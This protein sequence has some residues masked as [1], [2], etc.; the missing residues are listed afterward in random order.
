V[1][2]A[3]ARA[4]AAHEYTTAAKLA[5]CL[6]DAGREGQAVHLL[7]TTIA[8]AEEADPAVSKADRL[9]MRWM[10]AW[11]VGEKTGGH[12]DP[13]R[14]LGIARDVVR[15]STTIYGPAHQATLDAKLILARQ[16]GAV[17]NPQEALI[18]AREVDAAATAGLCADDRTTLA[19]GSRSPSGPGMWT[20]PPQALNASPN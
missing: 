8:A 15:D 10:L 6:G 5:Y 16:V 13:Q 17:G 19:P 12:G 2:P 4:F 3:F 11:H 1:E 20:V 14:A 18:I 7:E 9:A